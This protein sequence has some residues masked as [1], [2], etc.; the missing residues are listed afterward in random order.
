M[1]LEQEYKIPIHTNMKHIRTICSIFK[2]PGDV[3]TVSVVLFELV[4]LE[5]MIVQFCVL[6]TKLQLF[7]KGGTRAMISYVKLR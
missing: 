4:P 6:L 7:N 1:V 2:K 3:S 5:T